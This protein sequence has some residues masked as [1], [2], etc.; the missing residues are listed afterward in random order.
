M[1]VVVAQLSS[2]LIW[3]ARASGLESPTVLFCATAPL[4]WVVPFA[5]SAASSNVVL[6]EPYGP[7]RATVRGPFPPFA[8]DIISLLRARESGSG[9]ARRAQIP[10][11]RAASRAP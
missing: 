1:N 5:N 6:P 10:V 4:R 8:L 2:T 3:R 7:T 9:G 11:D